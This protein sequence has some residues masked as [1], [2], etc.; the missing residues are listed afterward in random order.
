MADI[1]DARRYG[2]LHGE[3][4]MIMNYRCDRCSRTVTVW[5][6]R[7]GVTPFIIDC[8]FCQEGSA[9]HVNWQEDRYAPNHKPVPGELVF[10]D[11]TD[12]RR[13]VRAEHIY[14]RMMES[15]YRWDDMTKDEF[16]EM[17]LRDLGKDAAPDL[18]EWPQKEQGEG[19][20]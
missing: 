13:R 7:D 3:A 14:Q 10:V 8:R 18:I 20:A 2:H 19:P 6:S 12:A 5:N 16:I 1:N 11:M 15:E 17:V 4:F 9:R